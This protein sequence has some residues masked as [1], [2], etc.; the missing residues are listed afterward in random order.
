MS[1]SMIILIVDIERSAVFGSIIGNN[2]IRVAIKSRADNRRLIA[3]L[4]Q[5]IKYLREKN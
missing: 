1:D 3:A 4:K 2:F 5:V